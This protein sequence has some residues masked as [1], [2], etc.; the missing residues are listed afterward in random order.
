MADFDENVRKALE[1]DE[2]F[3][4]ILAQLKAAA[5]SEITVRDDQPC[6]KGCGCKHIRMVRVPDYKTKLAIMEFL[7]NRGVGRPNQATDASDERI[8][9]ERVVY[10][11]DA[12]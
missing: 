10:M 7:A 6:P 1:D 12:A 5:S 2:T 11:G 9:F 3:Q 8:V 4:G